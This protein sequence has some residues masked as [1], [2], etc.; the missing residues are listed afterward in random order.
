MHSANCVVSREATS[1]TTPRPYWAT[2]PRSVSS[3]AMSTRVPPSTAPSVDSIVA[4]ALPRPFAS[5]AFVASTTRPPASSMCSRVTSARNWSAIGPSFTCSFAFHAFSP[6]TSTSSAPGMQG[7][8]AGTSF[9]SR[10]AAS[11]GAATSN[12]FSSLTSS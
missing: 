12:E 3:V 7:T 1:A 10:H 2:A 6:A 4:S 5:R 11:T 9:S 8:T